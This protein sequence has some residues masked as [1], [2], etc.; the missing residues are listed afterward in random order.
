MRQKKLRIT[1]LVVTAV[2]TFA[3]CAT[4][5]GQGPSTSAPTALSTTS[6]DASSTSAPVVPPTTSTSIPVWP[7]SGPIEPG[8]HYLAP[9]AWS[10]AGLTLTIPDGWETEHGPP[11][12]IKHSGQDQE[13]AFY[14]VV[15]DRLFSDPCQ[16]IEGER[17]GPS[18]DD[19]VTA[20]ADQPLTETSEPVEVMLG[21]LRA[22]QIDVTIPSDY[23][24]TEC[25][26]PGG[27]QIWYSQP[28]DKYLVALNDGTASIYVFDVNGER[29][30]F[31]TQQRMG[32]PVDDINE[33]QAIIESIRI[34][35]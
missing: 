13:L 33:L 6:I 22:T 24:A 8:T 32:T 29:Q 4:Q 26:A 21:G 17:I 18:V 10:L 2:V 31:Y 15:V 23:D 3:A 14:F 1:G 7:S 12:A 19:L 11:T 28:A 30:V 27:F 20:L 34:D 35:T 9:S 5:T 25:N 16:G